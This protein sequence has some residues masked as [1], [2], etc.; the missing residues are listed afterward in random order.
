M[1]LPEDV[2]RRECAGGS[3]GVAEPAARHISLEFPLHAQQRGKGIAST[4]NHESLLSAW[5]LHI[6]PGHRPRAPSRKK[7]EPLVGQNPV[8]ELLRLMSRLSQGRPRE[9][10]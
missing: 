9:P 2:N 8:L 7:S 4:H 1:I 10:L 5:H 3:R 6:D